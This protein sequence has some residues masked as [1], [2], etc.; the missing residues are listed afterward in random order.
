MTALAGLPLLHQSVDATALAA[1]LVRHIPLPRK[2]E[3]DALHIAI[4][5]V[6]GMQYLL[7]CNCTHIANAALRKKIEAVCRASGCEPPTICTPRELIG[8][9]EQS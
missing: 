7:S 8:K 4:A 2:A 9:E 6:H 5:T 1:S 3:A